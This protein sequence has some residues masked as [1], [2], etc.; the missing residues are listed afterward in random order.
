MYEQLF[1][2]DSDPETGGGAVKVID[3]DGANEKTLV[4]KEAG[5]PDG[6]E[7]DTKGGKMYFALNTWKPE[8]KDGWDADTGTG[9]DDIPF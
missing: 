5:Q 7:V 1:F 6:I 4:G 8:K 9:S 3:P 2:V